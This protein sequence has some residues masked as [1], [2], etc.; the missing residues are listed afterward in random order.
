MGLC[1]GGALQGAPTEPERDGG[2][3]G[4]KGTSLSAE[5]K[6]DL[7]MRVMLYTAGLSQDFKPRRQH[8]RSLRGTAMKREGGSQAT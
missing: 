4:I 3:L 6:H 5:K 8:L 7:K 1:L 2:P